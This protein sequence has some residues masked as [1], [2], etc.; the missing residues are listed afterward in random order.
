MAWIVLIDNIASLKGFQH[1]VIR[2][3][4]TQQGFQMIPPLEMD[5]ENFGY[6]DDRLDG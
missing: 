5:N 4:L 6:W 2:H 3:I 1:S